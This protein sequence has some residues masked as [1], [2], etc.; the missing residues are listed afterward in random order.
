MSF[1]GMPT[2]TSLSLQLSIIP[3]VLLLVLILS[4]VIGFTAVCLKRKMH[5]DA[6]TNDPNPVYESVDDILMKRREMDEIET[7]DNY[8]Y[9]QEFTMRDNSALYLT[10]SLKMSENAA[11]I[12][13]RK[14]LQTHSTLNMNA[15]DLNDNS[16]YTATKEMLS[17]ET[18][19]KNRKT[20][21]GSGFSTCAKFELQDYTTFEK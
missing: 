14:Q 16:A 12:S 5:R 18:M 15:F 20:D 6:R 9:V 4:L 11:Y 7:R 8:A 13:G 19:W 2:N 3:L 21:V 10:S 1:S 17:A